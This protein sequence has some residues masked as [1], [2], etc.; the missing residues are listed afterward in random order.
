M[1]GGG[2]GA[3]ALV[4][5]PLGGELLGDARGEAVAVADRGDQ[6]AVEEFGEGG[7]GVGVADQGRE[8][9]L[10]RDLAA[11]RVGEAEG[12][13]GR[14]AE[15]GGEQ[16]GG[17]G[18]LGDGGQRR[19]GRARLLAE[20]VALVEQGA[21][22]DEPQRQPLGLEP[23]VGG[24][25]DLVLTEGAAGALGEQGQPAGAA[26]AVED[27]LLDAGRLARRRHLGGAGEQDRALGGRGEEGVQGGAA[28]LGV[29]DQDHGPDL[30]GEFG[31]QGGARAVRGKQVDGGAQGVQQLVG[32]AVVTVEPD[33]AVGGEPLAAGGDGVQQH[34][35]AGAAGAGETDG[36]APGEE[37]DEGVAFA[38]AFQQPVVG[39]GDAGRGGRPGRGGQRGAVAGGAA[40]RGLGWRPGGQ[41]SISLPS[42]GLTVTR[43]PPATS[44]AVRTRGGTGWPR[45][46]PCGGRGRRPPGPGCGPP[47]MRCGSPSP[48]W[49]GSRWFG[50]MAEAPIASCRTACPA[51][52]PSGRGRV[53]QPG[54]ESVGAA[55]RVSAAAGHVGRRA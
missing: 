30:R 28:D 32:G 33:D 2:V 47:G 29:V 8:V 39:A 16:G 24:P 52:A 35:T 41:T 48:R 11:E 3:L 22:L 37:L 21:G 1:L 44:S 36:A 55:R 12:G 46:G 6:A 7:V 9:G 19:L 18:A 38:V 50:S 10:V 14:L 45:S 4:G 13:A 17:G 40:D 27:D 5:V 34:G 43:W 25:G 23:E 20:Q 42:T 54:P 26:H 15:P 49:C 31:E 53:P 51:A